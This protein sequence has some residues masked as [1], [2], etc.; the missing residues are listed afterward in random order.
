MNTEQRIE[1]LELKNKVLRARLDMGIGTVRAMAEAIEQY[2]NGEVTDENFW[3]ASYKLVASSILL[4]MSQPDDA[5]YEDP[6]LPI[7]F[8]DKTR[9]ILAFAGGQ[10]AFMKWWEGYGD[11]P[12][13]W[14]YADPDLAHFDTPQPTHF[15][16]KLN[17]PLS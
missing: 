4:K 14:I 17:D 11:E 3:D 6:W 2:Q 8:A 10:Q 12:A 15:M 5:L 1:E 7:E 13:C 9:E 16:P